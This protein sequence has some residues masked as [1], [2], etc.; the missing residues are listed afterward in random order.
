VFEK[1]LS[2]PMPLFRSFL[3]PQESHRPPL[4]RYN[5]RR[6]LSPP[7]WS[8]GHYDATFTRPSSRFHCAIFERSLLP[9]LS[10]DPLRLHSQTA[11]VLGSRPVSLFVSF[12]FCEVP[13]SDSEPLLSSDALNFNRGYFRL[14]KFPP[15]RAEGAHYIPSVTFHVRPRCL[16]I[17]L[18]VAFMVFLY[19]NLFHLVS[20]L[21]LSGREF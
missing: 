15:L 11:A 20:R 12:F 9:F 3:W 5:S 19:R 4:P 8:L 10:F 1:L 21:S 17:R 14:P 7:H 2:P 16:W 6:L 13:L 18:G